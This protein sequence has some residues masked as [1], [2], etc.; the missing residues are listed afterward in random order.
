M[1]EKQKKMIFGPI[2]GIAEAFV[3]QPVDTIK[4]LKQSNQYPV[5]RNIIDTNYR[6]LYRGVTP[7]I[8]H[9]FVKYGLRFATFESLKSDRNCSIL[10]NLMA[11]GMAGAME[12]LF[13]TPF[14]LVK[15]N[16]QT[17]TKSKNP[18]MAI[19]HI[20]NKSGYTGLY[21]G[22]VSTCFRQSTNQATNFAFYYKVRDTFIKP[23]QQPNIPLVM[24]TAFISGSIGPILNNPFDVV[25]TR[26]MNPKYNNQYHSIF[27]T[28]FKIYREEGIA[29]LYR[30]LPLRIVRL[31][32]GQVIAFSIIE[33]LMYIV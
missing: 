3:M 18:I 20:V 1:N 15:T 6:I 13:I 16:L 25:K 21:R 22:L 33:Q 2:A 7:F 29:S 28:L 31:G 12:S 32:G 17:D 14:E 23:N 24:G 9:S 30:G 8:G 27:S 26:Y 19:N 4:V 10:R 5:I 11:G